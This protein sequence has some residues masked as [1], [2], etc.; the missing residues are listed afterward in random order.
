VSVVSFP[1]IGHEY[2]L[3]L[4]GAAYELGPAASA[5]FGYCYQYVFQRG[6]MADIQARWGSRIGAGCAWMYLW[7][8]IFG[9][10]HVR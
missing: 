2:P 10:A 7:I 3:I 6:S 1:I 8:W 4:V 9:A 5:M